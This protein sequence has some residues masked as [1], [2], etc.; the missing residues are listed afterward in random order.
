MEPG[1][2]NRIG[3]SAFGVLLFAAVAGLAA[4]AWTQ[5]RTV[6]QLSSEKRTLEEN[7]RDLERQQAE[8]RSLPDQQAEIQKLREENKDLLRLRE[9][10]SRLRQQ[11]GT[12]GISEI[13]TNQTPGAQLSEV[14]KLREDNKDLL[15]LRNEVR[16]LREQAAEVEVLRAA[17]TQFFQMLQEG[18]NISN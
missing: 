2:S 5:H 6:L 13:G 3:R 9:E 11:T 7:V 15:R 14:E 17:N 4:F 16:Q 10:V 18:S 12:R 1:Q 8:I